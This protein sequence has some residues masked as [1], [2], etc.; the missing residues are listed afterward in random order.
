MAML[1]DERGVVHVTEAL[2]R[3][4][5]FLERGTEMETVP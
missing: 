1:I 3:R 2:Q 4:I 5:E